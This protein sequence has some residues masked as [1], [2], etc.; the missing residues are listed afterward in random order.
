MRHLVSA[1]TDGTLCLW[2]PELS[3]ATLIGEHLLNLEV[4]TISCSLVAN[5]II[6][7]TVDGKIIKDEFDGLN[8]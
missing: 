5:H 2:S 7:A 4:S 6:F 3:A 8:S 1:S